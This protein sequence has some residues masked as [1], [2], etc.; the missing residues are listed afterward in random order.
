ME[1]HDADLIY[2]LDDGHV[3]ERGAHRALIA[4]RGIYARL[5]SM[6][7]DTAEDRPTADAAAD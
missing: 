7:T 2:V 4:Q 6:Q 5:W 1:Q 3:I